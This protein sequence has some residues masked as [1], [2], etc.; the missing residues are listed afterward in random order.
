[1]C[2]D[3]DDN[4]LV[5]AQSRTANSWQSHQYRN[6]SLNLKPT[7]RLGLVY[8][9]TRRATSVFQLEL[10]LDSVQPTRFHGIHPNRAHPHM[11]WWSLKVRVI[12]ATLR[13]CAEDRSDRAVFM[14]ALLTR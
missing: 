11:C 5:K 2:R 10:S 7:C 1:M 13:R 14:G 12:Q 3:I 6:G 4:V 9:V 8:C